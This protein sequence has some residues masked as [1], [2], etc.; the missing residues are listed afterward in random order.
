MQFQ[1]PPKAVI[2]DCHS[3]MPI[4][5]RNVNPSKA[6][7]IIPSSL[8]DPDVPDVSLGLSLSISEKLLE[9]IVAAVGALIFSFGSGVAY[10]RFLNVPPTDSIGAPTSGS[11]IPPKR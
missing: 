7:P 2:L 6:S 8:K 9:K 3:I 10:G 11:V 1:H 5:R 4:F